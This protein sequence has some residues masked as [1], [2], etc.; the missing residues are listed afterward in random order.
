MEAAWE[1]PAD[2]GDGRQLANAPSLAVAAFQ[3]VTHF[4]VNLLD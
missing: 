3:V 2:T 4:S 1:M